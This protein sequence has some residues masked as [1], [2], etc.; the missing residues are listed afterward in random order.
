MA[1][2]KNKIKL[3]AKTKVREKSQSLENLL[4]VYFRY[5]K[6]N[7]TRKNDKHLRLNLR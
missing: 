1:L 6:I 4:Q 2:T 3:T 7:T 5:L